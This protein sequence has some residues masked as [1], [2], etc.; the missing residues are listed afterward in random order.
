MILKLYNIRA[1]NQSRMKMSF[2]LEKA[3]LPII[4]RIN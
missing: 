3:K 1:L 4:E 2:I